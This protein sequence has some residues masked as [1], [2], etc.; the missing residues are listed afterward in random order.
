MTKCVKLGCRPICCS[1]T[2]YSARP[3]SAATEK[4]GK[5]STGA[6]WAVASDRRTEEEG[7]CWV[8]VGVTYVGT[9]WNWTPNYPNWRYDEI[10][11]QAQ[12]PPE[13][14]RNIDP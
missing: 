11:K 5:V 6:V 2:A 4:R 1:N 8:T 14:Q 13:F 9:T 10:V 7:T 12:F 3:H